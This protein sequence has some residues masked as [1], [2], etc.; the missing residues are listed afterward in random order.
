MN[1]VILGQ[2]DMGTPLAQMARAAGHATLAFGSR[3]DPR[4][5]LRTAEL[6]ILATKYEQALALTESPGMVEA[7]SG[8]VMVDITNPLAPDFMS[9]TVGHTT[10]AAE[11]IARRLPGARVVKAFNTVFASLM[12]QRASG[13]SVAVPVFVTGDDTQA[14]ATVA[15]LAR[16]F[17]FEAIEGG[18]LPNAR[19]LEAMCEFMIQLGCGLGHGDRIG[20]G[21]VRAG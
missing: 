12:A 18:A 7:L 8:K 1:I 5:A 9:L 3:N 17:G 2:R 19:Y 11:E 6:V 16:A 20:F 10:S 13:A 21:L 14:V 15:E 4:Q